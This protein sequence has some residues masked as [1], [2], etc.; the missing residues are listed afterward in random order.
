[1]SPHYVTTG[2]S[3][4]KQTRYDWYRLSGTTGNARVVRPWLIV[5]EDVHTALSTSAGFPISGRCCDA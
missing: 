1:M 3:Q 4:Q 2:N 5:I